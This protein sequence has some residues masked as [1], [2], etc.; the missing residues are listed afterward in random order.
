MG[1]FGEV[2]EGRGGSGIGAYVVVVVVVV[3]TLEATSEYVGVAGLR[4]DRGVRRS[5]H[6]G[7]ET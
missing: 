1:S 7:S 3:T 4:K 2:G 6:S 5:I